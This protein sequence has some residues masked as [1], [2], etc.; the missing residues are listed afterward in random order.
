MGGDLEMQIDQRP[1]K[2]VSS[3]PQILHSVFG[4]G[5]KSEN[6][7]DF[8]CA[9]GLSPIKQ[10]AIPSTNVPYSANLF[11]TVPLT[12]N[13]YTVFATQSPFPTVL[14]LSALTIANYFKRPHPLTDTPSLWRKTWGDEVTQS[15]LNQMV[16]LGLLAP[17]N[18]PQPTPTENPTIL[19]AWLHITDRCNLRCSYCYLPHHRADM[20]LETGQ[21]AIDATFRSAAAHNYR[22]V[23]FKY[24][25]GEAMLRFPLVAELHK[26]AQTQADRRSLDLDG[27]VL[28]NGT[29]LTAKIIKAM[30]SLGLRLM[31]SLDRLGEV[32][33]LQQYYAN[34]RG[35]AVDVARSVDLA[36]AHGLVP[37]ISVT[38]SGRSAEGLPELMEW[39]LERNLPFSLNFYRENDFSASH[40][41][42][43]LEEDKII[44]GMLA[45]FKVLEANLPRRN[46]LASL[47]DRANLSAAHL[48][49]CSVGNNYLVF[50][51]SGQVHKCQMQMNISVAT[52]QADDPLALVRADQIGIR[53][54]SVEEKKGCRECEWK[55]WCAGGC[56]LTTYRATGRYDV[57]S[58]NCNIYKTLYP[59][60]LRLEGLRLSTP[61]TTL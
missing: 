8:A 28:S 7:C 61:T 58:P 40:R 10:V 13:Y 12:S 9:A 11:T 4:F 22:E 49:T 43:E 16:S 50:D 32:H 18:H 48:R 39:L 31:I 1:I 46:L 36:L 17:Q 33:D 6:Q 27:V 51:H 30:Q 25:G 47:V 35:S 24:A 54:I 23:K 14:N 52:A 29:L 53:N 57:K 56:P 60:A 20:S 37:D 19:S 42:L 3:D 41:D 2:F 45:A 5:R 15:S 38:V 26:H 55:Y 34:G 59:E 21:A 44:N